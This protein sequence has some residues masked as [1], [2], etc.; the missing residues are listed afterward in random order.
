MHMHLYVRRSTR[1]YDRATPGWRAGA[2]AAAAQL[3]SGE[4]LAALLPSARSPVSGLGQILIDFLPGPGVDMA[5]ATAQA[6]DKALLRAALVASAL[7]SG[8]LATRVETRGRGRWLLA[9]QGLIGGAAAASR[10]DNSSTLS[11]LAGLGAGAAGA[12]TLA[13]MTG[14]ASQRRE[15]VLLAASGL[16]LSAAGALH[17]RKRTV[18]DRRREEMSLPAPARPAAPVPSAAEFKIPGITPLFTPN[19]SFYVTDT[20]VSAPCVDRD[21]WRLRVCG[22]VEHELEFTVQDLLAM[23]LVEV[24]ATLGCVHNPVGGNWISSARWLG[25]PLGAL[26][27]AAGVRPESSQVLTH[28]VTGFTAGL[29][30]EMISEGPTPL[31]ALGMNGEPLTI[32]NGFPARLLTPGIWGADANTKWL[33]T[34]E[35]TTWANAS[36]YWDAR[37]WPRVPGAVKP[38]SRIDVPADRS[39]VVAGS[40][41]AAGIAWAPRRGVSGVE[42]AIDGGSWQQARL[43][44]QIA[45]TLWRQWAL[46]WQAEPGEHQLQVRTLSGGQ[47][48]E[49]NP[50]PPYPHGSSGYHTIHVQVSNHGAQPP[51]WRPRLAHTRADASARLRLAAAALSAWRRQGYPRQPA[52]AESL[53]PARRGLRQLLPSPALTPACCSNPAQGNG[54]SSTTVIT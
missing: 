25:V 1:R 32:P 20:T 42:V 12:G 31:I 46:T 51:R 44:P 40:A 6:K 13:L 23:E 5:V 22:L 33:A 35:L 27:G 45:P 8:Y 47:A 16:V 11:L 7:G 53:P 2:L 28:S 36:D 48:Q 15:R 49:E 34:I 24:D 30:L 41:I 54:I 43:S 17:R 37:G 19:R 52:F 4:L 9:A 26:L 29:P 10:P 39:I 50:A 3:G 21:R 18:A 14:K 38:G